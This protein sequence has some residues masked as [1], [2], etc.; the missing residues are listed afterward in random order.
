[1]PTSIDV[2]RQS[3]LH[4]GVA[5]EGRRLDF[6]ALLR[7][8]AGLHANVERAEGPSECHSLADPQLLGGTGGRHQRHREGRDKTVQHGPDKSGHGILPVASRR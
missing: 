8:D 7:E 4:P 3:L 5:V 6:D 2:G 1:M